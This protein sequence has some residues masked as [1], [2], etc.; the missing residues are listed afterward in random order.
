MKEVEVLARR[1]GVKLSE[2]AV[3]NAMALAEGYNKNFKPSMLRDLEWRRPI[4]IEALNGMVVR[5][6]RELGIDTPLN[7]V[8]YACLKL[9]NQKSVNPLW[10]YQWDI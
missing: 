5:L 8:I 9:E 3:D 1:Q 6:G 7:L 10:A 2:N 4:E